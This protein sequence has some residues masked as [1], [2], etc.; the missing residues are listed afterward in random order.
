MKCKQNHMKISRLEPNFDGVC[1]R[2]HKFVVV[3][4]IFIM[5]TNDKCECL[6]A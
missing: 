2:F 6:S 4:S 5:D 1:P 3:K